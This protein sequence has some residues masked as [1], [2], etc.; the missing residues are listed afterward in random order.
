MTVYQSCDVPG[1]QVLPIT[2]RLDPRGRLAE[3]VRS[4]NPLFSGFGQLYL[5]SCNPGVVKAWHMHQTQ[6]DLL[7]VISGSAR[8]G[9]WDPESGI[10]DSVFAG[11]YNPCLVRIPSGIWHGFTPVGSG[12]IVVLNLPDKL[13]NYAN[14]DES[15]KPYD[16]PDIPFDWKTR[17]G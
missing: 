17:S 2:Y 9:L 8:I 13:Y 12:E 15:R 4:D 5:T 14:P 10:G 6:T 3:I 16:T 11:E 7:F 1:V